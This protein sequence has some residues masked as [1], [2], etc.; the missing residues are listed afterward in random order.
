MGHRSL[1][2]C[3]RKM[4]NLMFSFEDVQDT[5]FEAMA[6]LRAQAL[7]ES[8]E[9]LGRFDPVRVRE[10]LR[11]AFVPTCMRHI[12]RSGERIGYLTLIPNATLP[13]ARLHHLYIRPG[14][15]GCGAGAW[16]LNWAKEQARAEA[17]DITL[18][19]LRGSDANR[20]YLRH[21]FQLVEEQEFDLE[22]LWNPA[23]EKAAVE[24]LA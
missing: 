7:Q 10:R 4:P 13:Q 19:A 16:A 15:Q 23:F 11:S 12:V 18:S 1:L 2:T 24:V 5:D 3:R 22:Y 9:R 6:E 8:L 20:F 21:G 17:R 14:Q